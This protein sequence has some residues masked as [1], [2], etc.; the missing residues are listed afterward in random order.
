MDA[1]PEYHNLVKQLDELVSLY[2]SLLDVVRTEKQLLITAD[3]E[4]LNDSNK[5]KELL[6]NKIKTQDGLREKLAKELAIKVGLKPNAP[7]LLEL[8]KKHSGAEAE[9]LRQLHGT[10]TVLIERV[11]E[12]NL[13]NENYTESA[14]RSLNLALGDIK[15]T[16]GGKKMYARKGKMEEG[17]NKSGNFV[18]KE[19]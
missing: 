6:L 1:S 12:I 3:I 15:N 16:I 5:N 14:L 4:K 19:A 2:Q 10:L 8:A 17:P 11:S 7:R 13:E 18:S 9:R